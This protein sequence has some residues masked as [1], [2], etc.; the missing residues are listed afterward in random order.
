LNVTCCL[1]AC[2]DTLAAGDAAAARALLWLQTGADLSSKLL[3]CMGGRCCR[4]CKQT[5]RL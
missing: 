5:L 1:L 3:P 4:S 2:L